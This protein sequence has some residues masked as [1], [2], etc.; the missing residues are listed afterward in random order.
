MRAKNQITL[1][2]E[3]FMRTG[4]KILL[5]I[6]VCMITAAQPGTAEL[7]FRWEPFVVKEDLGPHKS[8]KK[9]FMEKN[10]ISREITESVKESTDFNRSRDNKR[11][12]TIVKG[13]D[14]KPALNRFKLSISQLNDDDFIMTRKYYRFAES[15][16][17]TKIIK[18]LPNL[19]HGDAPAALE[20]LGKLV[21]PHVRIGVEF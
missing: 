2:A 13:N 21:E 11:D 20:N 17:I 18:E 9:F 1:V 7:F 5:S 16:K 4:I 10:F 3:K 6:A 15:D 12:T 8:A 14:K 19:L